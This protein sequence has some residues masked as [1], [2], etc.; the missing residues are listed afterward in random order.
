MTDGLRRWGEKRQSLPRLTS[1]E[2]YKVT[3]EY[4]LFGENNGHEEW[5]MPDDEVSR[6]VAVMREVVSV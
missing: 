6:W 2:G 4:L 3:Y 1:S 5:W